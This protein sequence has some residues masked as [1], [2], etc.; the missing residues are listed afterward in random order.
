LSWTYSGLMRHVPANRPIYGLQ[1][2]G[3][4]Q[5]D[6]APDTLEDMAADY[7][8]QI[9]QVQ[10]AGPYH[11]L[12]WSFG[13]LVAHAIATL[14]QGSGEKV[15]LLALLD[16]YPP[17]GDDRPRNE[18]EFD[19]G[20]FLAEQLKA[21]GYYRGDA[22][23]SVSEALDILRREGDLLSTLEPDQVTAI[24]EVF[25]ANGALARNFR[26]QRFDGDVLLLPATRGEAPPPAHVWKP[27]VGGRIEVHEIDCEHIDMMRPGPLATIGPVI[28]GA[29]DRQSRIAGHKSPD[30]ARSPSQ[31]RDAR[32]SQSE[33]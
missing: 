8:Q 23:L 12:G 10:P 1:A 30:E 15:A 2:R 11:L 27:Y 24:I 21:L 7:L 4:L 6:L 22:P 26:P 29:L 3:I 18:R 13:G 9:R 31:A 19:D 16:S 20:A 28:A 5:P 33:S 14:L 17:I 25:K 32:R